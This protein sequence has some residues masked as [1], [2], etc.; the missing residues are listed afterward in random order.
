VEEIEDLAISLTWGGPRVI[1]DDDD[2]KFSIIESAHTSNLM[3]LSVDNGDEGEYMCT[4][5]VSR[6]GNVLS[7]PVTEHIYISVL[8]PL[9]P[10]VKITAPFIVM[11]S[12]VLTLECAVTVIPHITTTP[13]VELLG[14]REVN[15]VL[16]NST[17]FTLTHTLDPVLAV[18]AGPYFCKAVLEVNGDDVQLESPI[19][20]LR[21]FISKE[22][23]QTLTVRPLGVI[24]VDSPVVI[25][26]ESIWETVIPV[27]FSWPEPPFFGNIS[28]VITEEGDMTKVISNYIISQVRKEH[29]GKYSCRVG[30]G[31][32]TYIDGV[33]E[34]TTSFY[35]R[36]YV[37]EPMLSASPTGIQ[38]PGS[39]VNLTCEATL[40]SEVDSLEIIW[41]G[42]RISRFS[43]DAY[44]ITE[45][46]SDLQYTSLLN[47]QNLEQADEGNYTCT[48]ENFDLGTIFN[49]S[50]FLDVQGGSS[51]T[52]MQM[53][54][55]T[56]MIITFTSFS[57]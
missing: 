37:P 32:T 56:L 33:R 15:V 8:A 21:V 14:P 38:K 39:S 35:L 11:D 4:V 22:P 49:G 7:A 17:N 52:V 27:S 13:F 50:I 57:L 19:R 31:D 1:S 30:V 47:I 55:L 44:S 2:S 3:I 25:T 16:A 34:Y 45:S 29:E 18:D 5:V 20:P 46:H 48:F 36:V 24:N 53:Q 51:S 42:P 23:T 26:C 41:N 43:D 10:E 40:P 12:S 54:L 9:P 28:T 6:G